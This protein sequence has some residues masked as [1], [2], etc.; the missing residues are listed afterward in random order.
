MSE[1]SIT[2]TINAPVD[3]VWPAIADFGAIYKF[4]PAVERSYVIN[5]KDRGIGAQRICEFY[6]GNSITEEVDQWREGESVRIAITKGSLPIRN[7]SGAMSLRP[8][9]GGKTELTFTVAYEPKFGPIGKLMDVTMMRRNFR[10]LLD[11]VLVGLDTHL[12]TGAVIGKDGKPQD[13]A[14]LAA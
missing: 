6:D 12:Q 14:T 9:P 3:Q 13:A 4:H 7:A 11:A 8:T 5:D 10:K 1:V 2:K